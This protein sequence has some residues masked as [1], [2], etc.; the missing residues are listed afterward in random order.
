MELTKNGNNAEITINLLSDAEMRKIGFTDC[1][2]DT[3]YYCKDLLNE[4]SFNVTV[5]KNDPT[6]FRIDVLDE[7]FCQPY[8]YQYLLDKNPN[9]EFAKKIFVLVESEMARLAALGIVSG[10]RYGEYI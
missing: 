7:D 9:F 1:V 6:D 5:K 3:W 8:D 4:I 2:K 10:H